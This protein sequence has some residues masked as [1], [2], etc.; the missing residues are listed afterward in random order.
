ML[1]N[2][3]LLYEHTD[4]L[5]EYA[6]KIYNRKDDNLDDE[7]KQDFCRPCNTHFIGVWDTVE[8]LA[9]DA[10]DRF[11]DHRLN[12]DTKYAYHAVAIDEKRKKFPPSLWNE[13]NE[14]NENNKENNKEQ[15]MEQV[16]FAG[17]HSDVGG[18]Y[19]DRGLSDIALEWMLRNAENA[20]LKLE[21]SKMKEIKPDPTAKLHNSH[22]K[23][24][25]ILG[26]HKRQVPEKAKVH[27]SV[28]TRQNSTDYQPVKP[29]PESVQWVDTP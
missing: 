2:I 25:K 19:Q 4:N 29:I 8:S 10:S 7:F 27:S 18:W 17:V 16:W 12:P 20:G 22:T 1:Y 11:H 15:T 3:G 13:E 23:L 26:T 5:V 21:H 9:A 24:W 28:Q 6:S 14:E